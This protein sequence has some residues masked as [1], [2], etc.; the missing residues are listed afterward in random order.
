MEK[1]FNKICYKLPRWI[2]LFNVGACSK[3]INNL[4]LSKNSKS[5]QCIY[6]TD[7]L[8]D[9]KPFGDYSF[10]NN[11]LFIE[12]LF[13][14]KSLLSDTNIF[15]ICFISSAF[16]MNIILWFLFANNSLLDKLCKL[17]WCVW[18]LWFSFKVNSI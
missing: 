15:I 2:K 5:R 14:S 8:F 6:T 11:V 12:N 4:K 1:R 3:Y 17:K 16:K 7:F 9:F 13:L 10:P 18:N